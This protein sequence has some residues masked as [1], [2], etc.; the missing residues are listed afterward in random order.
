MKKQVKSLLE[1]L[2][3]IS[4]SWNSEFIIENRA[5]HVINSA[6]NLI[7]LLHEYFDPEVAADLEKRMINSIRSSDPKK[8]TRGIKKIRES[9]HNETFS[10]ILKAQKDQ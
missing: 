5:S 2:N 6:I 4:T 3:D 7:K 1:E 9:K 8:F 10:T